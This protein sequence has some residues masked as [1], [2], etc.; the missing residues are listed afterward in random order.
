MRDKAPAF[1]WP[2]TLGLLA[3]ALGMGIIFAWTASRRNLDSRVPEFIALMLAAGVLYFAAI[4]LIERFRLGAAALLVIL[5]GAV[6]FRLALLP[7]SPAL[8]DDV[9]RY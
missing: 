5:A 4:Y 8:S 2:A 3:A 9:Y 6:A 7:L 1:T